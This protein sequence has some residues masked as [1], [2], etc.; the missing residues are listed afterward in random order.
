MASSSVNA[1]SVLLNFYT[2]VEEKAQNLSWYTSWPHGHNF[3]GI[4]LI[5]PEVRS[6]M[7]GPY[8]ADW[9][10]IFASPI[11]L[12]TSTITPWTMALT[13]HLEFL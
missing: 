10:T 6:F 12:L 11:I 8:D 9:L 4:S 1:T 3:F 13:F 7:Y 5:P 2:F